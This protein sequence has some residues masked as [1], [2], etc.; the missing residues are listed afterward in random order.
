MDEERR[1]GGTGMVAYWDGS[2]YAG[3]MCRGCVDCERHDEQCEAELTSHGYTPCRCDERAG[4]P[5]SVDAVDPHDGNTP[6]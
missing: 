3:E 2:A 5:V 4:R 6:A 1:C